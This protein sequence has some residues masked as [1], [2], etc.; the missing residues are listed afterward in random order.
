LGAQD[1]PREPRAVLVY[2]WFSVR[3]PGAVSDIIKRSAGAL[4]IEL[5]LNGIDAAPPKWV[6]E[7]GMGCAQRKETS[8]IS[9]G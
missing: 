6:G 3:I 8:A 9:I 4:V 7:N 1:A 5:T 2:F